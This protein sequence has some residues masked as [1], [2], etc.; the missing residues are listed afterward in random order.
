[1][2]ITILAEPGEHV[3]F[4]SVLGPASHMALQSS[5][6]LELKVGSISIDFG[7]MALH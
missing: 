2:V 7:P 6:Q 3:F 4:Q 1:M 5:T